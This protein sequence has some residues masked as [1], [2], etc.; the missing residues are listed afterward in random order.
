MDFKELFNAL[1]DGVKDG[2]KDAAPKAE[3]GQASSQDVSRETVIAAYKK[4]LD[5]RDLSY[6]YNSAQGTLSMDFTLNN[7]LKS[8]SVVV[9]L[10]ANAPYC[11]VRA[12]VEQSVPERR[13]P[14]LLEFIAARNMNFVFGRFLVDGA[15]L[16]YEYVPE[17]GGLKEISDDF[18][19]RSV[20]I[21]LESLKT[22]GDELADII[23]IG[24]N[25]EVEEA[26]DE[27]TAGEAKDES[28]FLTPDDAIGLFCKV[29]DGSGYKYDVDFEQKSISASFRISSRVEIA[30]LLI[31]FSSSGY[32]IRFEPL[33]ATPEENRE[34]MVIALNHWNYHGF[35]AGNCEMCPEDGR[36]FYRFFVHYEKLPTL[37]KAVITKSLSCALDSFD[38]P[39]KD[40]TDLLLGPDPNE[41]KPE[42][43][44]L[45][46]FP[47]GRRDG[48]D[49]AK[50]D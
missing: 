32:M 34:K 2:L 45:I 19:A 10:P 38:N 48:E 39:P 6:T 15:R 36:I 49:K 16:A 44:K 11:Q 5:A 30:R 40:V 26:D 28:A 8:V 7:R 33:T 18:I 14:R 47:R 35:S 21:P 17:Y 23:G 37:P 20:M 31:N 9:T 24:Q 25:G 41:Q 50:D 46:E 29:L 3:A 4:Y 13:R 43:G 42:A 12:H 22:T 1:K 27:K